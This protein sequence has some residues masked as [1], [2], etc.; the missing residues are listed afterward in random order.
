MERT[1]EEP[2]R[3]PI[4]FELW[5][6]GFQPFYDSVPCLGGDQLYDVKHCYGDSLLNHDFGCFK[7][8]LTDKPDN[9]R[10]KVGRIGRRSQEGGQ[11]GGAW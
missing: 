6:V 3:L 1:R 10:V 7:N 8:F 9:R 11:G 5:A 4:D 2:N